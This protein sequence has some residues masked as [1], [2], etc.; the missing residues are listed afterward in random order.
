MG[1]LENWNDG[2]M[3]LG[4]KKFLNIIGSVT[5]Y[6]KLMV[7]NPFFQHSM[8]PTFQTVLLL[9]KPLTFDLAQGTRSSVFN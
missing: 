8:I 6:S 3:V 9:A 5:L 7:L 1:I 2:M 4:A